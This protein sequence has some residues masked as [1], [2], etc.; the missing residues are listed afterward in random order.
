MCK[1]DL[2][3]LSSKKLNDVLKR[4]ALPEPQQM[5][6]RKC[7]SAAKCNSSK[8]RRYTND[9]L[10]LCLLLHICSPASCRLLRENDVLHLQCVKAIRR[11]IAIVKI[12]CR[13]DVNFFTALKRKLQGKSKFQR[14]SMLLL[15]EIQ[16]GERKADNSKTL[17]YTGLVDHRDT[18]QQSSEQ[19]NHGLVFMFRPFGESYAQPVAVSASRPATITML[20]GAGS[21]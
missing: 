17:S 20:E 12:K 4:S 1:K 13:F 6:L 11:Y 14:H 10:L 9:W 5:L 8:G 16:V 2:E 3:Q 15:D 7:I 21:Y 19:A 18:D